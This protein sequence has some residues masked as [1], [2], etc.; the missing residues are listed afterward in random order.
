METWETG[1][2][3]AYFRSMSNELSTPRILVCP[4]DTRRSV[5]LWS[6]LTGT[7][8]SYFADVDSNPRVPTSLLC[9]DRNLVVNGVRARSGLLTFTANT[10]MGWDEDMHNL[11]GNILVGDGSVQQ[12]T[13][14][15]LN[16]LVAEIGRATNRILI[17]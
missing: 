4:A 5:K 16:D 8:V 7:N 11:A 9:G 1:G 12:A 10:T 3:L 14:T 17:P 2:V 6:E 15:R 13:S